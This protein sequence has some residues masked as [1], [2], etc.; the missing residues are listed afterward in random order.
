MRDHPL[1]GPLLANAAFSGATGFILALGHA[2]LGAWL[3][4]NVPWV[5]LVLGMGLLG[6]AAG[7][8]GLARS[9]RPVWVAGVLVAD[10]G[11]VLGTTVVVVASWSAWEATG[12]AAVLITNAV[13]AVL[14]VLQARALLRVFQVPGEADRYEVCVRVGTPVDAERLWAAVA[15]LGGIADHMA[16][17]VSSRIEGDAS[18][19]EGAVRTCQ[20]RRGQ[21]WS[22]RCIRWDDGAAF[23]VQFLTDEP[24]FPFP[25]SDMVGGWRVAPT[26]SGSDVEVWWRVVPRHRWLAPL[27][28]PV[29]AQGAA[30]TFAGVVAS[31]VARAEGR[32]AQ[33]P[34]ARLQA[35]FC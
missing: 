11:W 35:T 21:R 1:R 2:R 9:P 3:G 33:A 25:F 7:L 15:D 30:R 24:G 10:V 26:P 27:L 16:D 6:F 4:P 28:L 22:E 31:M 32:P 18:P 29:M 34:P 19:G 20:N 17:L 14:V 12:L 8:V 13:V 23:D 5:Y